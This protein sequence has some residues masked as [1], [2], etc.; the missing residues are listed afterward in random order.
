MDRGSVLQC[1]SLNRVFNFNQ[2]LIGKYCKQ[3]YGQAIL[4]CKI[5]KRERWVDRQNRSLQ[6]DHP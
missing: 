3:E 4:A 2:V 1:H 5:L 6:S